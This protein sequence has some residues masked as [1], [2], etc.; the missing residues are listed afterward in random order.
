[1]KLSEIGERKLIEIFKKEFQKNR[2]ENIIVGIGDD[3]TVLKWDK[4]NY[5]V[6]SSDM[7]SKESH[8]PQ[9]MTPYQIGKYVVN[10]NLSDIASM[11]AKPLSLVFSFGLPPSLDEN[12]IKEL[13]KGINHASKEHQTCILG[14]DTKEHKEIVISGTAFGIVPQNNLLTRSGAKIGDMICVTGKIGQ[15]AAGFYVLTHNIELEKKTKKRTIKA[16]LEPQARVKEGTIIG[17]HANSCIDISDGLA[18]SLYEITKM[19]NVGATIHQDKI[20]TDPEIQTIAKKAKINKNEI[21]LHK[22]GDY[23]LL[24]TIPPEKYHQL[25]EEIKETKTKITEI[26]EITKQDLKITTPDGKTTELEPRGYESFI[27]KL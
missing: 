26:G 2:C 14:G 24:F 3:A 13:S 4:E 12:F 27:T 5:L 20:P 18:Y 16:A 22:G 8:I 21:I 11:G 1:M 6:I 7:I 10:I 9:E 15:A 19:S 25:K 17:R 23:E